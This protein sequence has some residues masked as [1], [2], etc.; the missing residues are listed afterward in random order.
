[1]NS[2]LIRFL[3]I[4]TL[5]VLYTS[6]KAV[7]LWPSQRYWAIALSFILFVVMV[8]WQFIYRSNPH[9][10]SENWFQALAWTGSLAMSLWATFILFSLPVDCLHL[11]KSVFI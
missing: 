10:F 2:Q 1:M 4:L 7:Q 5:L 6:Y 3:S 11:I 8:G 9:V